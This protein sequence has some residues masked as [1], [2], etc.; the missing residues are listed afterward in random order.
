M[1]L[2]SIKEEKNLKNK[3]VLLRVDFNVPVKD[4]KVQD[5]TRIERSLATIK[6]LMAKKAKVILLTHFG[7]P[8]FAKATAGAALSKQVVKEFSTLPLVAPLKKLLKAKVLYVNDCV[9]AGVINK[10]KGL[11]GGEVLLLENVRFY[12]GEEANEPKFAKELADLGDI[13]VN[14][15]FS[16][17]HRAHASTEGISKFITSYAGLNVLEEVV[18][19]DKA[20]IKFKKPAVAIIG[21][22]KISTKIA[23][24]ENLLKKYNAVMLGGGIANNFLLAKG[25]NIGLSV[26]DLA[27]VKLAKQILRSPNAKKL[28]LP[29]DV[30]I[31]RE[32]SACAPIE[33]LPLALLKKIKDKKFYIIDIGPQTILK[34]ALEIKKALTI[35]WNGP[36]GYFEFNN[37]SHGTLALGQLIALR[38]KGLAFGIVGGGETVMALEQSKLESWVDYI[39]T[40]GGAMLKYLEGKG[41]V[42]LK[43]LI[44]K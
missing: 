6:F 13:Y 32:L 2:R 33:I 31:A 8:A 5:A 14:D 18:N 25:Y 44:K 4:G 36:L 43:P 19:I 42:A 1:R 26:A 39:S 23:V 12:K 15:A 41:L 35:V 9:G 22:I 38:S 3:R 16:V 34:Y 17:S 40:G 30:L 10:I 27:E 24:I 20:I 11:N 28:L 21:G 29:D 37:F 7:R